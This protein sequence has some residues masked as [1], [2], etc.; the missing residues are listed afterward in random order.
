MK[1][2]K[3]IQILSLISAVSLLGACGS[4]VAPRTGDGGSAS[5]SS[6]PIVDSK[7]QDLDQGMVDVEGALVDVEDELEILDIAYL[8]A[9]GG[10][11]GGGASTKLTDIDDKIRRLLA[12]LHD[13]V[14]TAYGKVNELYLLI[15]E[16]EAKLD[17]LNP[18]HQLAIQKL[19][20][21]RAR[22]DEVIARLNDLVGQVSTKI[23]EAV[24]SV[25]ERF[26]EMDP[27]NAL[28][29][30]AAL[31]WGFVKPPLVEYQAIFADIAGI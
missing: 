13:G 5:S 21:A 10:T 2:I 20:E 1:A 6:S 11:S 7:L 30:I 14:N 9:G 12:K 3:S 8:A 26:A 28:T 18:L 19:E 31:A 4:E 29:M 22:V 25:D 17:P 27:Q 23:G 16:Q 15:D 24:V